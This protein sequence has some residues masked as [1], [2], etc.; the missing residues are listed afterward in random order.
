[1]LMFNNIVFDLGRVLVDFEPLEYLNKLYPRK[2]ASKLY[3]EIFQSEE[4]LDLDRGIITNEQAI[5]TISRRCPEDTDKVQFVINDW[6]SILSPIQGSIAILYELKN[7]G[8]KLY[9]LSNFHKTAFLHVLSKNLFFENFDG[10]TV[11]YTKNLIK[12]S[13]E[14]FEE[15]CKDHGIDP[16][17][18]IFI[19]DT[20]S[21]VNTAKEIGFK[22]V[23]FKDPQSLRNELYGMGI[24]E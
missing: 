9:L 3:K 4:W 16:N 14:I 8:F 24:L 11:S 12:P 19:D 1:M 13:R 23:H 18:S 2:T 10:M 17:N 21:N 15:L 7:R 22:T 6:A 20:L 5:E